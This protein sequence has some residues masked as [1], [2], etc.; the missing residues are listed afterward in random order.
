MAELLAACGP[1]HRGPHVATSHAAAMVSLYLSRQ[2]RVLRKIRP[3][4]RS[5][6]THA[7]THKVTL[8]LKRP[9]SRP[10]PHTGCI[11][12]VCSGCPSLQWRVSAAVLPQAGEP[13]VVCN[14]D[15]SALS[16]HDAVQ[17]AALEALLAAVCS[18][19][20]HVSERTSM[21]TEG[22]RDIGPRG[23]CQRS[24]MPAMPKHRGAAACRRGFA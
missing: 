6:R 3:P 13:I 8:A 14:A 11:S 19:R 1:T 17:L 7:L 5:T 23:S 12:L 16:S 15:L 4:A 24:A 21:I 9:R 2:V 18:A 22:A 10:R 20:M